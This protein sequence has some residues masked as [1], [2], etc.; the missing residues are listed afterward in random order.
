MSGLAP[1]DDRHSMEEELRALRAE[2]D[3][4]HAEAGRNVELFRRTLDRELAILEAHTLPELL[5]VIVDGLR[6]SHGVE[7]VSLVVQD[8]QHEI[9]HL[10][11]GDGY[12]PDSFAGVVFTDSVVALAPQMHSLARPWLGPYVGPDHQLLFPGVA[13]LASVAILP[14][15]RGER[16]V[17]TLNFGSADPGRFTRSH[18]SDFLGHLGAMTGLAFDS[19]CN[20]ARLVRAGLTDYLTGWHNRRY[21]QSR[22]R[23]EIARSQRQGTPTSML[24]IDLD[25]FKEVNDSCGHLGGD[26]AICEVA[27]RIDSQVRSS[28]TAAR[29]GGD[30][31]ALLLPGAS[32]AEASHIARRIMRAV[33]SSPVELGPG[34]ARVITLSVGIAVVLPD[35]TQGDLKSRAERLLAEADAALYRAKAAGRNCIEVAS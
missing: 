2:I 26:A 4:L 34:V 16:L 8:P 30:E 17:G 18:G 19:A 33:S 15:T 12:R 7:A 25:R 22:M 21:L 9:R 14:L 27:M 31:F 5:G 10:L 29:F 24:M 20:R 35:A 28:D 13:G 1:A 6:A 11:L 23:E 3:R 32:V